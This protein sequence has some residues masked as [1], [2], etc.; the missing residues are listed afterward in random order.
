MDGWV[1]EQGENVAL[2]RR[3]E[4][5]NE[6]ADQGAG[7]IGEIDQSVTKTQPT[8]ICYSGNSIGATRTAWR[9]RLQPIQ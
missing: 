3:D 5:R 6:D 1:T 4:T 2:E 8:D 7:V 9:E